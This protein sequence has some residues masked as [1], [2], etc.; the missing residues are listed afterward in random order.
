[1][2]QSWLWLCTTMSTGGYVKYEALEPE[3]IKDYR[4]SLWFK[5]KGIRNVSNPDNN[6]VR[7]DLYVTF[8]NVSDR[9]A[10]DLEYNIW[11]N[12]VSCWMHV[13]SWRIYV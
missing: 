2:S 8:Y 12:Q 3:K 5:D 10:I 6:T 4:D 1:M 11:K 13:F 7:F 9:I